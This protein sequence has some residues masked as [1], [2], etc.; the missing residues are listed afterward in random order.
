MNISKIG[1]EL[2]WEPRETLETGL[3]KTVEWYLSH[4]HWVE[5]IVE[6]PSYTDWLEANYDER[7]E[8]T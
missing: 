1:G 3:R 7:G 4:E 6:E 5:V 2:G 8:S